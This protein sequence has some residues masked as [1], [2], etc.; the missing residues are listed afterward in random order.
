MKKT[1]VSSIQNPFTDSSYQDKWSELLVGTA[2]IS[3]LEY[4]TSGEVKPQVKYVGIKPK[5]P[6]EAAKAA[7]TTWGG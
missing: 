4:S 3:L 5:V 2:S 1:S 7:G 6:E